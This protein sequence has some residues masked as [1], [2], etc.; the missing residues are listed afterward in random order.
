MPSWQRCW[1]RVRGGEPH[2]RGPLC[3]LALSHEVGAT[4]GGHRAV[5]VEEGLVEQP[6]H[7]LLPQQPTHRLVD[8]GLAD[9]PGADQ[10]DH[11]LWPGLAAE[12][13]TPGVD[14]LLRPD[15]AR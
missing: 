6:E 4:D 9:T 13:V 14:H 15:R 12:L 7:E 3:G 2:D 10:L 11:Q 1:A 5:D 8:A